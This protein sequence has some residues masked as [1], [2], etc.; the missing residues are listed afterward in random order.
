MASDEKNLKYNPYICINK[1]GVT[2]RK[3]NG[4]VELFSQQ[5]EIATL[6]ATF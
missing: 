4:I 2:N 6:F 3:H 5:V 1:S